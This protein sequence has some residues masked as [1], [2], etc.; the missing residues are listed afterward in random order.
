MWFVARTCNRPSPRERWEN[1]G[2][3]GAVKGSGVDLTATL[4]KYNEKREEGL[5]REA[6][7]F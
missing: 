7:N 4:P 6:A 1:E 3:T 5:P 2:S